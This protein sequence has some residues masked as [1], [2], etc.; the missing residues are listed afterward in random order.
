MGIAG[1]L[2]VLGVL[3]YLVV[4]GPGRRQVRF[5]GAP[6][7][8][9]LLITL[10]TTRADHLGCYGYPPAKTPHLDGLAREGIRFARVYCPAPLTLPSHCSI[11]SGLYPVTHGVRNNGHDLPPGIKTLADILKGQGR[12]RNAGKET[13]SFAVLT[14]V[15]KPA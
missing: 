7:C 14:A 13:G 3:V 1:T 9:V 10:D 12:A 4:I 2:A 6:T 15:T 8:S 11:M 5:P